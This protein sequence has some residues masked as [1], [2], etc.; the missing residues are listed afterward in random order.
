MSTAFSNDGKYL[1]TG[2]KSVISIFNTSVFQLLSTVNDHG[3]YIVSLHFNSSS[4][5]LLSGAADGTAYTWSIPDLSKLVAISTQPKPVFA[6]IFLPGNKIATS[7]WENTIRVWDSVS[8]ASVSEVTGHTDWVTCL[9]LATDGSKFASGSKD[10]TA[11]VYDASTHAQL[12]SVTC[13]NPVWRIAFTGNS[14]IVVSVKNAGVYIYYISSIQRPVQVSKLPMIEGVAVFQTNQPQMK[15]EPVAASPQKNTSFQPQSPTPAIVQ[16][17]APTPVSAPVA[18]TSSQ[19]RRDSVSQSDLSQGRRSSVSQADGP[20][21]RKIVQR[22]AL[23]HRGATGLGMKIAS[24]GQGVFVSDVLPGGVAE[25]SG[26]IFKGDKILVIN[27]TDV[28]FSPQAE[29]TEI[30]KSNTQIVI[31]V[32][33]L[34]QPN[35]R[36]INIAR[37]TGQVLGLRIAKA[38]GV[39]V[40]VMGL[41]PGSM[42]ASSGKFLPQDYILRV[43][44]TDVLHSTYDEVLKLLTSSMN[45]TL[46]V[47][48]MLPEGADLPK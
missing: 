29:V 36:T 25:A 13:K 38:P 2:G 39:G 43:N 20:K 31:I 15:I 47:S 46:V 23:L 45:V 18:Q 1:A 7:S 16:S 10:G 26:S 44:G 9:A 35:V 19:P 4:T 5:Q 33:G 30:L 28:S 6:G 32:S 12:R 17:P 24:E 3:D 42:A 48:D 34:E 40:R 41:V 27:G 14:E 11:R 8:G 37:E 21:P 22:T